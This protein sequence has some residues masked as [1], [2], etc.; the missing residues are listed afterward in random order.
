MSDVTEGLYKALITEGAGEEEG[1]TA[2]NRRH[3]TLQTTI[4]LASVCLGDWRLSVTSIN[5]R[6]KRDGMMCGRVD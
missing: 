5:C 6:G 3:C 1:R 2:A 4:S